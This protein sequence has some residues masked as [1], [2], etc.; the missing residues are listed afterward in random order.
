MPAQIQIPNSATKGLVA[1]MRLSPEIADK[2][3][4]ALSETP[5]RLRTRDL[6][7]PI[8]AKVDI[9]PAEL[10]DI[11]NVLLSLYS[12][13]EQEEV[14]VDGFVDALCNAIE[15]SSNKEFKEFQGSLDK[16]K[17]RL[18]TFLSLEQSLGITAKALSVAY[19]NPRHY[20]S[21][22]ILTDAR[23]VF[24]TDPS[25]EPKAFVILHSLRFNIHEEG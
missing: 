3:C 12:A 1:L 16:S 8:V 24:T 6:P 5:P 20:H 15:Q 11:V 22:R 9:P 21:A 13:R 14:T 2:L 7:K 10:R 17:A 25:E 4:A 18:K 23:P 19:E